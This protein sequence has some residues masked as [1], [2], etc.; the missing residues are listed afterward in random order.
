MKRYLL[1]FLVGSISNTALSSHPGHG[2]QPRQ[3]EAA[4]AGRDREGLVALVIHDWQFCCI[5][6]I[7]EM[8]LL[9]SDSWQH[10]CCIVPFLFEFDICFVQRV[11][12]LGTQP[13]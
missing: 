13:F 7:Y 10:F 11:N 3:G 6:V 12:H 5:Y 8:L 4:T 9:T 2:G 1:L